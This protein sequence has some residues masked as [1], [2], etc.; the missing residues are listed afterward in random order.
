MT[1]TTTRRSIPVVLVTLIVG[2]LMAMPPAPGQTDVSATIRI[3]AVF[4]DDEGTR[5]A[6]AGVEV[7]ILENYGIQRFMC[8]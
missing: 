5:H 2:W 6:L 4:V 8:L 7:W 3:R 1:R